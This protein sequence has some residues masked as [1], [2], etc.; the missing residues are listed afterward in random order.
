L[1][2]I[3]AKRKFDPYL[4]DGSTSWFKVRNPHE[5]RGQA[6]S[7]VVR[8]MSHDLNNGQNI[9]MRERNCSPGARI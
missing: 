5:V 7:R 4:L 6:E 1:E 9:V 3:V 8:A 2:G